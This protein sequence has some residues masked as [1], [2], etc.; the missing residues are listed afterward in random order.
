MDKGL[1]PCGNN[2]WVKCALRNFRFY[3]VL[4]FFVNI[5]GKTQISWIIHTITIFLGKMQI[6]K[7]FKIAHSH[8]WFLGSMDPM[9][10]IFKKAGIRL[11]LDTGPTAMVAEKGSVEAEELR[12]AH[13]SPPPNRKYPPRHPQ[14]ALIQPRA[15]W[16]VDFHTYK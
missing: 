4:V 6:K 3:P 10:I 8:K 1:W 7:K 15:E 9:S 16:N 5:L 13:P 2:S 12:L 14:R 11:G